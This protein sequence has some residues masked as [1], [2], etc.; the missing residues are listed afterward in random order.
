MSGYTY[1]VRE[2]FSTVGPDGVQRHAVGD[3]IVRDAPASSPQLLE[4]VEMDVAAP[5]L[6][7]NPAEPAPETPAK[8]ARKRAA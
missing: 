8:P 7:V 3:L 1:R 4:P 5:E 2:A 6:V